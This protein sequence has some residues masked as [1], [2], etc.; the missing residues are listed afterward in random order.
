[1]V[2][3]LVTLLLVG[4]WL[5]CVLDVL[6]TDASEMRHLSKRGWF[7]VTFF[8]FLIGSVLW[9][10]EGR[11]RNR[12]AVSQTAMPAGRRSQENRPRGPEDDPEFLADLER[13]IRG[14]DA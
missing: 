11:D 2:H 12:I 14:E 7:A 6:R 9:L 5:Y 10:L 13:R 1:M 3:V 4:V 8:G